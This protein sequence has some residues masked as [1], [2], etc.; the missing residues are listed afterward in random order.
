MASS[1]KMGIEKNTTEMA[2]AEHCAVEWSD[3]ARSSGRTMRGRVAESAVKEVKHFVVNPS[4]FILHNI[5]VT[6]DT[7]TAWRV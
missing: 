1:V 5:L 6:R 3:I 4:Y 2:L 7:W